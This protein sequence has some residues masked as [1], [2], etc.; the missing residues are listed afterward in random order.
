MHG[1]GLSEMNVIEQLGLLKSILESSTEYAIVAKNLDRSILAWNVGAERLYGYTAAEVIGHNSDILHDP[2]DIKS[3]KVQAIFDE[4][5]RKEAWSGEIQSVRNDGSH[6]TEL[7]TI[8]L[9]KNSNN[10]PIGYTVISRDITELQNA[11]HFLNILKTSEELLRMQNNDLEKATREAQESNRIKSEFLANVSHELRTPLNGIIGF[12][13]IIYD[14]IVGPTSPKYKKFLGNIISSAN[15]LL[16]LINDVL[17]LAKIEADKMSF[18]PEKIDLENIVRKINDTFQTIITEKKIQFAMQIDPTLQEINIDS[19]KLI[20]V[21]YNYISNAL[22]FTPSG[23]RVNVHIY[24]DI[25]NQFCLEV[26]DTGIGIRQEDL[27]KLFGKFYQL[28]S[29]SSKKYPGTGLG[30][31]LT[32]RIVEAQGG[33]VGVKSIY[34][35]GSTFYAI[36]PCQPHYKDIGSDQSKNITEKI[37]TILV[38]EQTSQERSL[39]V[40]ALIQEGYAV[41]TAENVVSATEE[42]QKRRFDAI[43]LDLLQPDMSKWEIIRT[44][45][46]KLSPQEAPPIVVK[47]MIE[48]PV[49]F[50]FKIHD[51]LIKP[52]EPQELL[53][54]LKWVGVTSQNNKS[55][56][57]IDNNQEALTFANQILVEHGFRVICTTNKISG[58]LALEKQQPD[59]VLLDPFMP[60]TDGFE[61]LRSYRQTERGLHTPLIIWTETKLTLAERKRFKNSIERVM[62]TGDDFKRNI[63]SELEQHLPLPIKS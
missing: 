40:N 15:Q 7:V 11:L 37:P 24:P 36:L 33:K 34:G 21:F 6:F 41:V 29:G 5:Q 46:S 56:L 60:G 62:L 20:Q 39:I 50:G 47:V 9:R 14:G 54:A 17:D 10:V 57:I 3:G 4:V 63:L 8:T 16:I 59:V 58:L 2:N 18:D 31:A 49:S 32:K 55:I 25:H 45:R 13:E 19:E 43:I 35:K 23:G 28:D 44:L 48:Q 42:H 61:F 38:V 52:V 53:S 22:K 1:T 51:F 12:A 26:Q 30:L 27:S